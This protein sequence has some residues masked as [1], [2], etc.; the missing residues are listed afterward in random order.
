MAL[1][2]ARG[3]ALR[4]AGAGGRRGA[5]ARRR[6]AAARARRR[7]GRLRLPP[8]PRLEPRARRAHAADEPRVRRRR[9]GQR[10]GVPRRPRVRAA[11]A[12]RHTA[13]GGGGGLL[14]LRPGRGGRRGLAVAPGTPAAARGG[15][16]PRRARVRHRPAAP[17]ARD[18]RPRLPPGRRAARAVHDERLPQRRRGARPLPQAALP[19]PRQRPARA[20]QRPGAARP[21]GAAGARVDRPLAP[22]HD[23]GREAPLPRFRR[24][25]GADRSDRGAPRRERRGRR[26]AARRGGPPHPVG[27]RRP[28]PDPQAPGPQPRAAPRGAPRR[29]VR[30]RRRHPRPGCPRRARPRHAALPPHRRPSHRDREPRGGRGGGAADRRASAGCYPARLA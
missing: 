17:D 11:P 24:G 3:G 18:P 26:R 29:G 10:P 6:A 22:L 14:H 7:G 30:G 28:A 9:A 5:A 23:R 1:R 13:D 20:D 19:A 12:A 21:G 4:R 16:E 15:R 2:R 27:R 25:V 8:A